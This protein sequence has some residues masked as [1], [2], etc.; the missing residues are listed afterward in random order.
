MP[1]GQVTGEERSCQQP[2]GPRPGRER[3]VATMLGPGQE[4]QDRE[5]VDG[6]ED[7]G[8]RRLDVGEAVE[9]PGEGDRQCA[10]QGREARSP[11]DRLDQADGTLRS[12]S[13]RRR[14]AQA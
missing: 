4:G 13:R 6:P 8:R 5:A 14:A 10:R 1:E 7:R 9:D 2:E 12:S 11:G 3:A